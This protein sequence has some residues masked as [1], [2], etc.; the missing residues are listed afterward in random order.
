MLLL[1]L[2]FCYSIG[3]IFASFFSLY[4]FHFSSPFHQDSSALYG[5]TH[6]GIGG[7]R[8]Q[9]QLLTD[10]EQGKLVSASANYT[11]AAMGSH[12]SEMM[13]LQ[14]IANQSTMDATNSETTATFAIGTPFLLGPVSAGSVSA[15]AGGDTLVSMVP[16]LE[17]LHSSSLSQSS[18]PSVGPA[19]FVTVCDMLDHQSSSS[20]ASSFPPSSLANG[21]ATYFYE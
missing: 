13:P 8:Q 14:L 20:G 3:C 5:E 21:A 10:H 12:E 19:Y 11:A 9:L 4:I 17:G 1:S 2:T 15:T 6:N 7:S 18:S 16:G